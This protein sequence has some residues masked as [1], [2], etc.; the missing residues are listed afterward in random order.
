MFLSSANNLSFNWF[1]IS[2]A[3]KYCNKILTPLFLFI[4]FT[5]LQFLLI[6]QGFYN[7]DSDSYSFIRFS[8]IVT[9]Y[10]I[11]C[12]F[13]YLFFIHY[14]TNSMIH[15]FIT[16]IIILATLYFTFGIYDVYRSEYDQDHNQDHVHKL[17]TMYNI[18]ITLCVSLMLIILLEIIFYFSN[19]FVIYKFIP[20]CEF[21]FCICFIVFIYVF[22]TL[23]P[24][25][26][27]L[28]E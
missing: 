5:A 9:T 13:N 3:M 10:I 14:P 26:N 22:S 8:I 23:D 24:I 4:W 2:R 19:K 6:I 7:Y 16:L 12:G 1:S 25:T 11:L 18:I 17:T 28:L 15:K 21:A 20:Y 27:T